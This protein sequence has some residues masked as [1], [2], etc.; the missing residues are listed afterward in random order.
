VDIS[1]SF[2]Q[3]ELETGKGKDVYV[4]FLTS[5]WE[6]GATKDTIV[7][8]RRSLYGLRGAPRC[9]QQGLSSSRRGM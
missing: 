1:G 9:F 4:K 7:K 8:L 2:L 3:E 5:K 6:T